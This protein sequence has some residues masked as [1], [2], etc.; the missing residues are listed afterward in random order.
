MDYPVPDF[1]VDHDIIG[2]QASSANAEKDLG[3]EWNPES[4]DKVPKVDAEFKLMQKASDSDPICSSAGCTQYLH[5]QPPSH[6]MNYPVPDYGVDHD[7]IGTQAS[8][9]TAEGST[10]NQWKPKPN[11]DGGYD[12]PS[13]L[14]VPQ[15]L[16]QMRS[17]PICNSS[18]CT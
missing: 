17:D 18:G 16:M 5:P 7:I 9:K 15:G 6:P 10:G 12:M 13:A 8:I 4:F 3:T 14:Q 11:A 2:T 1:G